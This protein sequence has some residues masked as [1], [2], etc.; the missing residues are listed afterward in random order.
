MNEVYEIAAGDTC[1]ASYDSNGLLISEEKGGAL[2]MLPYAASKRLDEILKTYDSDAEEWMYKIC[3]LI[4]RIGAY[5][6]A[7]VAYEKE[8]YLSGHFMEIKAGSK[9]LM[10]TSYS[11]GLK[12]APMGEYPP[13]SFILAMNK[14]ALQGASGKSPLLQDAWAALKDKSEDKYWICFPSALEGDWVRQEESKNAE[15]LQKWAPRVAG[16]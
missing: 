7:F 13:L 3:L 14:N 1:M 6:W 2:I 8:Y 16:N 9:E 10:F 5:P 4:D 15:L 11:W 12:K